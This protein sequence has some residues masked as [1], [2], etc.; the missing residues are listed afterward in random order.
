[1]AGNIRL[2]R[3]YEPAAAEDG[4]RYLVERLWPRGLKKEAARLSGWLKELAPSPELRGWYQHD[5]GKWEEFQRRYLTE[6]A[7]PAKQ[8]LIREL[9]DKARQGVVTLVFATRAVEGSNAVVLK[10]LLE[11]AGRDG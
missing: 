3:V 9:A 4:E 7:T 6:L 8:A 5:P 11:K 10:G 1:M 2:K